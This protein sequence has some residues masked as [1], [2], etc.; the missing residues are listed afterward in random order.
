M[1]NNNSRKKN[2][3]NNPQFEPQVISTRLHQLWQRLGVMKKII[4]GVVFALGILVAINGLWG[5]VW[6]TEPTVSL[7]G[8]DIQNPFSYPLSIG[9]RSL[10]FPMKNVLGGCDII[11]MNVGNSSMTFD[12]V[13]VIT[14]ATSE[15]TWQHPYNVSCGIQVP[16]NSITKLNM[17]LVLDYEQSFF[18]FSWTRHY[19]KQYTMIKAS[20]GL[21]L[22]EGNER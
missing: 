1:G 15:I 11:H 8:T 9:N 4:G 18:G 13:K 19:A 6:P 16:L 22:I 14:G 20:D 7:S 10:L 21:H 3:R 5:P 17:E 2:P 12:N